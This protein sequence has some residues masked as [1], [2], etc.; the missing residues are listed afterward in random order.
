[1]EKLSSKLRSI[2]TANPTNTILR[3]EDTKLDNEYQKIAKS[4]PEKELDLP[5]NFDG[6]EVWKGLLS[7]VM[8]QGACGSCWAFASTSVLA[9]RFN[10]NSMGQLNVTLSP[11]KL[12]LCDWEGKEMDIEHPEDN[13]TILTEVNSSSLNSI[14][15][16]GNTLLDA[17]RFLYTIGTCTI[18]CI[19]YNQNFG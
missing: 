16:F 12:I 8:E 3:S 9:D 10:I 18:E 7:P 11:T 14:A 19:P 1:M 2:I 17:F 5:A 15:C 4:K 6:R 13:I